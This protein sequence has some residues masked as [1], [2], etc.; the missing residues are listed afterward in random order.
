[1][2]ASKLM[3]RCLAALALLLLL[4]GCSIPGTVQAR[5]FSTGFKAGDTIRYRIHTTASGTIQAGSQQVPISSDHTLAEIIQVASV[6]AAGAATLTVTTE[7]VT[8]N[9]TAGSGSTAPTSATMVIGSDGRIKS[10]AATQLNGRVPSLPGLDQLTPIFPGH[11]VKPGDTWTSEDSRPNP[12]GAGGFNFTAHNRYVKD[13]A[14]GGSSAAVVD[15]I[16]EG[17][18]DFT[19][20][21][22]KVAGAI[23]TGA[24]AAPIH[25]TGSVNNSRRYWVDLAS[26]QVL[27]STASG[28]YQLTYALTVPA[29]QAGGP[30][31]VDFS[32]KIKTD[33][34]RI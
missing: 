6:D 33:L 5:A 10:G 7:D 23:T 24:Q 1:M 26:H 27:K 8:G 11:S 20:D 32:G 25:Y 22:T 28:T 21:F 3:S 2:A 29:G 14:V 16:L 4:M 13:E 30:Q 31:Q 15:T 9:A 17:P 18:V 19:I 12:F 34:V